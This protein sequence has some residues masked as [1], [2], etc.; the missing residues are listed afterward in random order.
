MKI[1]I[2]WSGDQ[3]K[4]VAKLLRPWLKKV[5]QATDPWMSDED[6][7]P[8]TRWAE[9]IAKELA[10]TD[11][12]ILCVT[13]A[14]RNSEWLNFEAGALSMAISDTERHVVPL[15]IRFEERGDLGSGPLS[16]LNT[17]VFKKDDMLKLVE[18]INRQLATMVEAENLRESFEAFWPALDTAVRSIHIEHAPKPPE[19]ND[20]AYLQEILSYV[21]DISQQQSD[22]RPKNLTSITKPD[23]DSE[24]GRLTPRETEIAEL[25]ARGLTNREIASDLGISSRVV[26]GHLYRIYTKL[27]VNRRDELVMMLHESTDTGEDR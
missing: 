26:E 9:R 4:A 21:K 5:L 19:K 10:V 1:F 8:G 22:V 13:A 11:F 7:A 3:S 24:S 2:S 20:N 6:I 16:T 25:A 12:G 27:E 23:V 15:L 17:L 18:T 14:N